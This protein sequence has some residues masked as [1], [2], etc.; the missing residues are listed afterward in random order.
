MLSRPFAPATLRGIRVARTVLLWL[1]VVVALAQVVAIRHAYSHTPGETS[2]QSGGKHPGGLAHCEACIA[3]V[4]L[5]TAA[6]PPVP[7]LFA[8]LAQQLP[9]LVAPAD[10]VVAPRQQ[11]YAIRAP[12]AISS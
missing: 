8:A 1:A 5:G 4:A 9:Q 2:R 12:P 11:P 3:A 10:Q 6:P 7:L